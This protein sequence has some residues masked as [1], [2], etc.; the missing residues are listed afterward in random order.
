M[1][2]KDIRRRV[3]CGACGGKIGRINVVTVHR[4]ATW[5]YPSSGNLYPSSGNLITGD[6][7]RA[8]GFMCDSCVDEGLGTKK[9]R[10]VVEWR[11]GEVVYHPIDSLEQ[12]PPEK[13]YHLLDE[14]DTRTG[15]RAG[16]RCLIC[17]L[18]SWN[19]NDV[20]NRYCGHCHH[21]HE[22]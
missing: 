14:F 16:I 17:G 21:F 22:D 7:H 12:L 19:P 1:N 3:R 4:R 11:D 13:T 8:V 5:P 15:Y 6:D 10:E 9:L 2:L 18:T 20:E